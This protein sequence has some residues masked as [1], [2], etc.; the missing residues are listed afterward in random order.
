M[1]SQRKKINYDMK[2][3]QIVINIIILLLNTLRSHYNLILQRY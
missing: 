1:H 2:H 3:N